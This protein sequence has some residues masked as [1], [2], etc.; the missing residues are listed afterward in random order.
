MTIPRSIISEGLQRECR[1]KDTSAN[2]RLTALSCLKEMRWP[3]SCHIW[4]TGTEKI[5]A[6]SSPLWGG[7]FY[8]YIKYIYLYFIYIFVFFNIYV[9]LKSW[10]ILSFLSDNHLKG[11]IFVQAVRSGC[12]LESAGSLLGFGKLER[13]GHVFFFFCLLSYKSSL[14]LSTTKMAPGCFL[15]KRLVITCWR[16]ALALQIENSVML[17][18]NP[19]IWTTWSDLRICPVKERK[20]R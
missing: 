16:V 12:Y 15:H 7:Y 11:N 10:S 14:F 6:D 20:T 1:G 17:S 2:T 8:I 4:S 9:L 3:A 13:R 18:I 19:L 5:K